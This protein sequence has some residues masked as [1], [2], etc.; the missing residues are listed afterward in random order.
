MGVNYKK[1][2]LNIGMSEDFEKALAITGGQMLPAD[3]AIIEE[4]I[5]SASRVETVRQE[6]VSWI[7]FSM[8]LAVFLIEI[9]LKRVQMIRSSGEY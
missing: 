1:E 8:A 3:A 4:K 2:Y 7:F 9:L 6:S 5:K